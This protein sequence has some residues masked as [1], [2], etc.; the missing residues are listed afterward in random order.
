MKLLHLYYFR[1]LAKSEHLG[2]TAS[3]LYISSSALSTAIA[4]LEEE[5]GVQLFDRVG[6]N[7]CLNE[8]GRKFQAHVDNILDELDAACAE[9]RKKESYERVL[10]VAAATHALWEKPISE[11]MRRNPRVSLNHCAIE[12]DRL[13]D[14]KLTSNFDFLITALGDVRASNYNYTVFVPDDKPLLAVYEGHPLADRE[15][16]AI[17]E[18]KDEPFILL[19]RTFSYRHYVDKLFETAGFS[20]N[21]IAE[22]D[23]ALRSILVKE[24]MGITMTTILCSKSRYLAGLRFIPLSDPVPPRMQTIF[25]K[26]GKELSKDA[27]A[28]KNFMIA[29]YKAYS[30]DIPAA[31]Q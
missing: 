10:N 16:V 11:F 2:K 31:T 6:R 28:F 1:A 21:I 14:E 30:M 15:E 12:W 22:T 13:T 26:K 19:P 24:R 7:I 25:W 20:P 23:Y 17:S 29:Y 9:L 8:N 4:R 5:L 3:E 18:L 27:L